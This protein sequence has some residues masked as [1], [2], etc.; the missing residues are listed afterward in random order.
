[1][2]T[3]F[4]FSEAIASLRRNWVMTFAS[5]LTVLIAMGILGL[6]LVADRN[7]NQGATSLKN[8][9]EVDVFLKDTVSAD[10]SQV[11]AMTT[12][13]AAL[14]E[15]RWQEPIRRSTFYVSAIATSGVGDG[16][17]MSVSLK[18]CQTIVS[19][20]GGR[21]PQELCGRRPL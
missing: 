20:A 7:L 21:R 17:A 4:F 2:K 15:V 8:R 12:Q 10:A 9:V 6:V 3:H 5:V 18:P 1:V 14:P 16:G 13:I 19:G 11:Q